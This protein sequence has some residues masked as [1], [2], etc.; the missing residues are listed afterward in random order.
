ML[1]PITHLEGKCGDEEEVHLVAEVPED[2]T[3]KEGWELKGGGESW[4]TMG[5]NVIRAAF[6]GTERSV[7]LSI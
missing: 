7:P 3:K 2:R 1:V 4:F 5:T 6:S